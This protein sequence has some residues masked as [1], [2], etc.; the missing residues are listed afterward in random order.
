M[1]CSCDAVLSRESGASPSSVQSANSCPVFRSRIVFFC[2]KEQQLCQK[3]NSTDLRDMCQR[4]ELGRAFGMLYSFP[5]SRSLIRISRCSESSLSYIGWALRALSSAPLGD[6][7]GSTGRQV[8]DFLLTSS[9]SAAA[10]SRF[11]GA[12]ASRPMEDSP[13]IPA[14]L[15]SP[16]LRLLLRIYGWNYVPAI[17]IQPKMPK[18]QELSLNTLHNTPSGLKR[19]HPLT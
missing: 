16:L 9:S 13:T 3:G 8:F 6:S 5:V 15:Y 11:A 18:L 1:K 19:R 2:K 10:S 14:A 12:P 4:M 7:T 17:Y